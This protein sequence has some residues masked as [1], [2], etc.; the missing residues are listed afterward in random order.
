MLEVRD[1]RI[2]NL[3]YK[4]YPSGKELCEVVSINKNIVNG[5][6]IS[7]I[8]PIELTEKWLFNLGF[9]KYEGWDDQIYWC[10]ESDK[11]NF[12][13]FELLQTLQGFESASGKVIK[14]VHTLQNC[15]FFHELI[16]N[17]LTIK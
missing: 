6:G 11:H 16:G 7:A 5:L 10:L 4:D 1:L 3:V 15:F 17:E 8:K 12:N 9:L 2:G 13:R 14:Y